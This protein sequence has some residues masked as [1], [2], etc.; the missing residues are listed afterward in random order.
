M[1]IW[2]LI[3]PVCRYVANGSKYTYH[4]QFLIPWSYFLFTGFS[5][6][7]SRASTWR[8][9][10]IST[11]PALSDDFK[12]ATATIKSSPRQFLLSEMRIFALLNNL[13]TSVDMAG[14]E[15]TV[16]AMWAS[17]HHLGEFCHSDQKVIKSL[18]SLVVVFWNSRNWSLLLTSSSC[19]AVLS[20][21]CLCCFQRRRMFS[22]TWEVAFEK[23]D[24]AGVCGSSTTWA[25]SR[26]SVSHRFVLFIRPSS[27]Q[28]RWALHSCSKFPSF[29]SGWRATAEWRTG[30]ISVMV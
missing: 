13:T 20:R 1:N 15:C 4:Y 24:G 21:A 16:R 8:T 5:S 17:R 11:K 14:I 7:C 26:N 30:C 22:S 12:H 10:S 9:S 18:T 2:T 25:T 29:I 23:S 28:S 27:I 3:W 19:S 6:S